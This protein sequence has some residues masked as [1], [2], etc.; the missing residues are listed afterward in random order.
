MCAAK[1]VTA[2]DRKEALINAAEKSIAAGGLAALRARDLAADVGCAVGAIYLA[3]PDLAALASAVRERTIRRLEAGAVEAAFPKDEKRGRGRAAAAAA[4]REL[5]A[6][7]LRFARDNRNLW[8]ALFDHRA[9]RGV[10]E[11]RALSS[12][13]AAIEAQLRVLA[14]EAPDGRRRLYAHALFAAVHGVITLG[15]DEDRWALSEEELAWQVEAI[16][17]AAATGFAAQTKQS[18]PRHH[19]KSPKPTEIGGAREGHDA[20]GAVPHARHRR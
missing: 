10:E 15:L 16:V 6:L 11:A 12:I 13:F 2:A 4:L 18:E 19:R 3:F 14:P 8:Q 7:Y 1:S 9:A 5:A 20:T 17:A